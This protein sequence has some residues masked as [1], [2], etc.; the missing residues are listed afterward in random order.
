MNAQLDKYI[1]PVREFNE[2]TIEN[3]EK[4][5]SL[6][7]KRLEENTR[8]GVDQL[9]GA[10]SVKDVEGFKDYLGGCAEVMRLLT[11]K[12]VEDAR[13]AF[14]MG[15]TFHSEAQRIFKDALNVN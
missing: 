13:T 15:N 9:K 11:E 5:V 4:I 6:Q 8:I 3:V 14:E 7:I 1:G 10:A 12:A 2:L